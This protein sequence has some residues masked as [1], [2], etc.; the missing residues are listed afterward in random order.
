MHCGMTR[1]ARYI[2]TSGPVDR[3]TTL[4]LI[5]ETALCH[6]VHTGRP[7]SILIVIYIR[8]EEVEDEEEEGYGYI[9]YLIYWIP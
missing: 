9:A 5:T 7:K 1:H 2:S 6:R 4:F 3:Y 8:K